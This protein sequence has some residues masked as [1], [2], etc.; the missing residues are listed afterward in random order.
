MAFGEAEIPRNGAEMQG[1]E[2]YYYYSLAALPVILA[3]GLRDNIR[4]ALPELVPWD[5]RMVGNHQSH[6]CSLTICY[7]RCLQSLAC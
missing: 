5:R 1:R 3:E 7:L 6:F 2:G 4:R